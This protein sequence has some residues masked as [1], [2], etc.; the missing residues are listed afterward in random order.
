[1]PAPRGNAN[2]LKHGFYSKKFRKSEIDGL[3]ALSAAG[4]PDLASEIAILRVGISRM[5]EQVSQNDAVDWIDALSSIGLAAIR[6]ATILRTQKILDG[7]QGSEVNQALRTAI[8]M[9]SKDWV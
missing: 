8:E 7:D 6:V 2:A 9:T 4:L 5:F 1:M 3:T